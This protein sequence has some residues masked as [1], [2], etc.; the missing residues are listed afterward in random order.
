MRQ[1]PEVTRW[2]QKIGEATLANWRNREKLQARARGSGEFHDRKRS[3]FYDTANI[4]E[5]QQERLRNC[6]DCSGALRIDSTPDRGH[7][8]L[9]VHL[10]RKACA[11][12]RKTAYR[13][14]EGVNPGEFERVYLQDRSQ[15]TY[16]TRKL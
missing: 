9:A 3:I 8:I 2:I 1:K 11:K 13:W 15:D 5:V 16:L 6:A 14:Y 10:P 12:C 7:H 4:L